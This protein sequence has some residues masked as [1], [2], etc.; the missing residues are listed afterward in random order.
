MA[1]TTMARATRTQD[2]SEGRTGTPA[3]GSI[4]NAAE[5]HMGTTCTRASLAG[6]CA[7]AELPLL[8]LQCLVWHALD[9]HAGM[10]LC[11]LCMRARLTSETVWQTKKG[12]TSL[13]VTILTEDDRYYYLKPTAALKNKIAVT[14]LAVLK[15]ML[16]EDDE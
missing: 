11:M 9:S 1:A 3:E 10:H 8:L 2:Y 12:F 6:T 7:V 16:G 5:V 4:R 15:N 14:S 13:P